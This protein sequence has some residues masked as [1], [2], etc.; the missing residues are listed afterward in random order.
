MS[1]VRN[2]LL[3]TILFLSLVQDLID[4]KCEKRRKGVFGPTAGENYHFL[5]LDMSIEYI[6]IPTSSSSLVGKQFILFID[7][8]NMPTKEEY[9]A[10]PPIE[11]IRQ[12]FDNEG[13]YDRKALEFRKI[14]DTIY[15]LACGPPGINLIALM[16]GSIDDD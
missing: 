5:C 15:I 2:F 13:W 9:G 10:Q 11:I 8:V 16:C 4:S 12:W 6:L 1:E 14:I 3:T 7:D